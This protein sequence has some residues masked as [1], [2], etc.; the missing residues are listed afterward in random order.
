MRSLALFALPLIAVLASC[1]SSSA[2]ASS[3]AKAYV[4]NGFDPSMVQ[5]G[6]FKVSYRGSV[7]TG[8]LADG[9]S[10]APQDVSPGADRAYALV[11]FGWT[12][13]AATPAKLTLVRTKD[14][15]E[16]ASG[17]SVPIVFSLP[18]HTGKCGSPPMTEQEYVQ[19]TTTYFPSDPVESYAN[20]HCP[21]Q[22]AGDAGADADTGTDA[23]DASSSD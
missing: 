23:A 8:P 16:S 20:I 19:A 17:A 10:S 22:P 4:Q 15:V 5:V 7:F 12:K 18:S 6:I 1:S 2:D 14:L 21:G 3:A 13:G 9:E 11:A